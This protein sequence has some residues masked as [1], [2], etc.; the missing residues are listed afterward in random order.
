MTVV[1]FG[2]EAAFTRRAVT[3]P[4]GFDPTP[5]IRHVRSLEITVADEVPAGAEAVAVPIGSTGDTVTLIG[6]DRPLLAAAGFDGNPGQ[7]HVVAG[8]A[9]L[10][11]AVGVGDPATIDA[12]GIRDAAAAFA[13]A[14]RRQS[15]LAVRVPALEHVD[16]ATAAQVIVEGVLLARYTYDPL[17]S[18]AGGHARRGDHARRRPRSATRSPRR[19]R[20]RPPPRRRPT[21][22]ARDL[23]NCRADHLPRRASPRSPWTSA[24]EA[25]LEVEVFDE[26]AAARAGLRRHP[27]RQPRQ[28]RR[29]AADQADLP[30]RPATPEAAGHLALV[31]KGIMYDSGGISLK[32][33]DAVHAQMKNDMSGAAAVLGGDVR[34]ARARLPATGHRLPLCTDNMP[35]GT[36][37]EARRR[38]HHPRRHDRRGASTPTPRAAS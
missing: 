4:Q 22:L 35:S 6:V 2:A 30:P 33:S 11:V 16:P 37:H 14:T 23:A 38:A 7:T 18:A 5:S 25:G 31:G 24:A 15:H 34:P 9:P 19:G 21:M 29:A 28:R 8:A 13:L 20:A 3:I 27:R 17:K 10:H 1:E 12:D 32:P 36:A 26:D